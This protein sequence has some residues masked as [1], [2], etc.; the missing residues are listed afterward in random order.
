MEVNETNI[1]TT[2][3]DHHGLIASACLDLSIVD[4]IDERLTPHKDRIVT[5]GQALVAMILNGLGFTNRRLYLTPQFFSNKPVS[6]L[7]EDNLSA[8]DF[9]DNTLGHALDDIAEYGESKL[10]SEIAFDIATEHDL[11]GALNHLD[12]TSLSVQGEYEQDSAEEIIEVTY[13]HSK[14]HR[15]DLKQVV[16]SLVVSGPSRIPVFMEALDGNSSDKA[17]FHTTIEKVRNFKKQINLTDESHWVADSALY[18]KTKLLASNNYC[19]ISRVPENIAEAKNLV[20]KK[21]EE[22]EWKSLDDGDKIAPFESDYG[23]ISQRWILVYSEQ[24]YQREKKT[25]DKKIAK[26]KQAAQKAI[27]HLSNQVFGCE[28]DAQNEIERLNNKHSHLIV[29]GAVEPV[30]QYKS[31]GRPSKNSQ[32]ELVG[33]QALA[34]C[35]EDA[36]EIAKRLRSK[37]RFII[38]TNDLD[39]AE[40]PDDKILLDYKQQ[41]SVERGFRFL[42]DPFFMVD[43]IFLKSPKR[44]QALMMVM[45]MCL[46]IYNIVEFQIRKKLKEQKQTILNQKKTPTSTP[47]LRSIF[48]IMEGIV[49]INIYQD[50]SKTSLQQELISNLSS[51][52]IQIIE[53]LGHTACKMYGLIQ[54]NINWGP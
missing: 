35:K 4:K 2:N 41:Q 32:K 24:S 29:S 40:L 13:G 31:K 20:C 48:Q 33:Y 8:N 54:R 12:T 34:D 44:I 10:F 7:F 27:W 15:P 51:L 47:T 3:L 38:A 23:A 28:K 19:W 18:S 14:D 36:E 11:L 50:S 26:E 9:T 17:S 5:P 16:L 25:F 52:R 42:K 21:D 53:L 43:S 46:L 6:R 37:G 39:Q 45:T 30:E 1:S 49:V 22:V